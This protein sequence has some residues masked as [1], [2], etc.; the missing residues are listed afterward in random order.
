MFICPIVWC[1]KS[2]QCLTS[3]DGYTDS[4]PM[5]FTFT[6]VFVF[7][8]DEDEGDVLSVELQPSRPLF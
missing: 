5:M 2:C 3:H 1:M 4:T 6:L 8:D 7:G